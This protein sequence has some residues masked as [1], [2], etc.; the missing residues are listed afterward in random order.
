MAVAKR[1]GDGK[2]LL[3]TA[4]ADIVRGEVINIDSA[5]FTGIALDAIANGASGE[6]AIEG[7]YEV[8]KTA[9]TA[10]WSAGDRLAIA[11]GTVA[12]A[13]TGICRAYSGTVST[14]T[15]AMVILNAYAGDTT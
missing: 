5:G 12:A 6:V 4:G 2:V 15:T 1:R 9:T 10:T 3:Y 7:M 8:T 14:A 13:A 11:S